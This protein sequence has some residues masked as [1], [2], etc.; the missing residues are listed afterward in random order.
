MVDI[1]DRIIDTSFGLYVGGVILLGAAYLFRE[2][3]A[4]TIA[5]YRAAIV[6]SPRIET[7]YIG[8]L[9]GNGLPETYIE[10]DGVRYFLEIDGKPVSDYIKDR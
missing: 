2:P 10:K 3:L 7:V 5:T 1:G 8:D 4:E 6:G 9:N